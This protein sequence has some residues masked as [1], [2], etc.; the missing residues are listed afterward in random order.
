MIVRHGLGLQRLAVDL[1]AVAK[2]PF[3]IDRIVSEPLTKL[4]A[5]LA[6]V[7]LD[8]VL[9]HVLVENP[10]DRIEDLGLRHTATAIG[11]EELEDAPFATR[12]VEGCAVDFRITS[13]KEGADRARRRCAFEDARL[14]RGPTSDCAEARYNFTDVDRLADH[15]V[16]A[17]GEQ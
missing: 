16:E 13:V 7:A 6:D 5:E 3:G 10:I 2:K 9:F 8:D 14:T 4:L 1:N 17:F 15:I 11:D 12:Q